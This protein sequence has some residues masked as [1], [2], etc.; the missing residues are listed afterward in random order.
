MPVKLQTLQ[1]QPVQESSEY[2]ATLSSRRS[3]AIHPQVTGPVTHI[4]V[5]PGQRVK[6]GEVLLE[7]NPQRDQ[8]TLSNLRAQR[9]QREAAV[10]LAKRNFERA[11]Q[12]VGPGIVSKQDYESARSALASAQ[13]ELKAAQ[14]QIEAQATQLAYD[15]VAAPFEGIVGDIPVK[16]GDSV[17]PSTTLTTLDEAANLQAYV[18]VPLDRAKEL[19]PHTVVQLLD[20]QGRTLAQQ[21]VGFVSPQADPATQTLLLRIDFPNP[22]ALRAAQLLRAKVIWST[23]PGLLLPAN[24]V[25]RLSGQTFAFVA[26]QGDGGMVAQQVPVKLG[27][28]QGND[29]VVLSGLQPG[30]QVVVSGV[31]QLSSGAALSPQAAEAPRVG[32]P[33]PPG[34][35]AGGRPGK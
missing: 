6:Q 22:E 7:I 14:A 9:A 20:D 34:P 12:L 27:D 30:Q 5:Q 31:Q 21:E 26:A 29:Y 33:A 15:R 3:V 18:H 19:G 16:V 8:A 35:P 17:S 2:L 25:Q 1:L 10:Q 28:L 11:K 13:A 24:A 4:Y 32:R 23:H